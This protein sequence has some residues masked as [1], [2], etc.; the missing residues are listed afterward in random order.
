LASM[1]SYHAGTSLPLSTQLSTRRVDRSP[2]GKATSI[3]R[4]ELGRKSREGS[5]A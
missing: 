3:R 4:P 2:C 1:G 5:S